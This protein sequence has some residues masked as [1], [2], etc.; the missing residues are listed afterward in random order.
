MNAAEDVKDAARAG[1]N[2]VAD[3]VDRL[4]SGNH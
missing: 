4:A 2:K 3:V 1:A